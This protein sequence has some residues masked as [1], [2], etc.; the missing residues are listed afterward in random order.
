MFFKKSNL[1]IWS[2]LIPI[3]Y[4]KKYFCIYPYNLPSYFNDIPIVREEGNPKSRTIRTC[5]GFLNYFSRS[6]VFKSPCD[7]QIIHDHEKI[8]VN[9][10]KE[11]LNDGKRLE[12]HDNKQFLS[13]IKNDRY[14]TII[15][16]CFN[17]KL[18][19]DYPLI[20]NNCWYHF[21]NYEIIPG[22][23]NCTEYPFDLNLFLALPKEN[24]NIFIKQGDPLCHIF[25]E[26]EKNIKLYFKKEAINDLNF[27]GPNYLFNT[28]KKFFL[29]NK[30]F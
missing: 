7:I 8:I 4:L 30:F 6:I 2:T 21:N 22:V 1:K 20:I 28:L 11:K 3:D 19:T 10:G 9:Y 16:L 15:K 13:Y 17:I 18:M 27:N 23:L 14:K 25:T 24:N 26:S 29:K 12:I 5:S